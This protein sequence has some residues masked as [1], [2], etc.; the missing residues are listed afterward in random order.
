MSKNKQAAAQVH[1]LPPKLHTGT[2]THLIKL[3]RNVVYT[4]LYAANQTAR[5]LGLTSV[6][7]PRLDTGCCPFP[8]PVPVPRLN[9]LRSWNVD[10]GPHTRW[11][12]TWVPKLCIQRRFLPPSQQT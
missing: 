5:R 11:H 4:D 9:F 10:V 7:Y 6:G 3:H 1:G 8:E 12:N 2:D